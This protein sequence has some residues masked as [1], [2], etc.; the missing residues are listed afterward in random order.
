MKTAD[1]SG[2]SIC[3]LRFTLSDR[4]HSTFAC[5]GFNVKKY[6][7]FT[8]MCW[9]YSI[10][11]RLIDLSCLSLCVVSSL[12]LTFC[13][14]RWF[15]R[16]WYARLLVILLDVL[17]LHTHT[18]IYILALISLVQ[19]N[20]EN[21]YRSTGDMLFTFCFKFNLHWV[22]LFFLLPLQCERKMQLMQ[23][24]QFISNGLLFCA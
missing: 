23:K 21:T 14:V 13:L 22:K 2:L 16:I 10:M 9:R 3:C 8:N 20:K 11:V 5:V 24:L 15:Q 6:D 1:H 12:R 17:L 19:A 4:P 7:T 18:C